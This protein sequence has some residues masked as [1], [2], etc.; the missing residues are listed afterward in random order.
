MTLKAILAAT[1]ILS[2]TA[3]A[4]PSQSAETVKG[5]SYM[6]HT[7][8]PEVEDL[9]QFPPRYEKSVLEYVMQGPKHSLIWSDRVSERNVD[10]ASFALGERHMGLFIPHWPEDKSPLESSGWEEYG[11]RYNYSDFSVKVERA[12]GEREIAGA[13][14]QHYVLSADYTRQLENDLSGQRYQMHADLWIWSD[15]PFSFAPFRRSGAY[16][17][18]RFGAALVARLSELGMV[19]RSDARHTSVTIDEDGQESD[20]QQKGT[21][22]TWISELEAADV[23]V[24]NMPKGERETLELL[25]SEFRKQAQDTCKGLIA[26]KTPDFI[27]DNLNPDQQAAVAEDLR[28]SCKRQATRVFTRNMQKN[29]QSVCGDILAKKVPE[30]INQLLSEEEQASFMQAAVAFCEKQSLQQQN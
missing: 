18:P 3:F 19:A 5:Y 9:G 16:S 24:V 15:K 7:T 8:R 17:D 26:G 21:W 27:I 11:D 29:P 30:P 12:E 2:A 28:T 10:N 20:Y 4:L 25:Q 23:P 1:I 6:L 22:T 13:M 14:A